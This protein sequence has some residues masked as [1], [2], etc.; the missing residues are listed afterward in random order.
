MHVY[1]VTGDLRDIRGAYDRSDDLVRESIDISMSDHDLTWDMIVVKRGPI[2]GGFGQPGG[3]VQLK[4]P[5]SVADLI[6]LGLLR[7]IKTT[8]MNQ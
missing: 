7:E 1:E 3:G 6:D 2:A 8:G 4:L 5:L